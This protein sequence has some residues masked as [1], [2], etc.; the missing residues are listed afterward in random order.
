MTWATSEPFARL[1]NQGMIL[2]ETGEKMSKS[3]GNVIS[4]DDIVRDWGADSMRL[5]EMFMGPLEVTKP[6]QTNGIA[7]M[8]R[9]LNR[10]WRL[11]VDEDSAKITKTVSGSD[12]D[13][14]RRMLHKTIRKVTEDTEGLRFNTAISSMIEFINFAY[15]EE[16]ISRE[17]AETFVLLLGPYA[18]HLC[19]ELWEKLGYDT[20]LAWHEWPAW[21]PELVQED[22]V[23]VS[24]QVNGK[25]RGHIQVPVDEGETVVLAAARAVENVEKH[26]TGRRVIKEVYVPGRIVNFVVS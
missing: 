23:T 19:E 20:S 4:P 21:D 3:R 2:G 12:S 16:S 5:Y 25:L 24:V 26:L 18:P 13:E 8:S 15:K 17:S 9:F 11:F 14:T 6:W 7:G 10:A 1:F 22:T